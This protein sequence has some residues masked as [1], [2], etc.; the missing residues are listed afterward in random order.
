M[1]NKFKK[2]S[3]ASKPVKLNEALFE[4]VVGSHCGMSC[5]VS[6]KVTCNITGE[7]KIP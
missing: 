1:N 2:Q 5:K 3:S 4:N 7:N 6:C